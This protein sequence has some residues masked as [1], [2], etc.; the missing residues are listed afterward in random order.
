PARPGRT[1]ASCAGGAR[2]ACAAGQAQPPSPRRRLAS[3]LQLVTQASDGHH[4]PGLAGV[5]LDLGAQA[6]DVD[7]DELAVAEV[8]V[9]P[10]AVEQRLSA[11]HPAF[12]LGQ[13]AQEPELRPRQADLAAS[14]ATGPRLGL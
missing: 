14:P 11:Q 5:L 9:P 2:P 3:W 7:V 6:P 13:L 1:P 4:M 12:R 8:V 10:H